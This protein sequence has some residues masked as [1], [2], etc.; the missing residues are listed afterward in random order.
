M[1]YIYVINGPNL[2]ML[3]Q[4]EPAIYGAQSLPQIET[5]CEQK[6][7]ATAYKLRFLQSN[8]EGELVNFIHSACGEGAAIAINAA[9]YSHSSLAILDALQIFLGPVVEI[10]LSNIYKRESFRH[11]SYCAQRADAVISGCGALG[12]LYAIDFIID[13]LQKT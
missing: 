4:R 10:H 9:A 12:Y 8:S 3:G 1:Q 13:Q 2:N 11:H 7:Q 6:L 5:L